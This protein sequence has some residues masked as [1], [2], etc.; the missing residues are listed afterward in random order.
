M[1]TV[2]RDN[3][4]PEAAQQEV[5]QQELFKRPSPYGKITYNPWDPLKNKDRNRHPR[6]R[7][8]NS[9]AQ[10]GARLPQGE[11]RADDPH[12]RQIGPLCSQGAPPAQARGARLSEL[13]P[14]DER[15]TQVIICISSSY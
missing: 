11:M 13:P 3:A 5:H 14:Q 12:K 10:T 7:T 9:P 8:S 15:P 4:K 1:P 6:G 2:L